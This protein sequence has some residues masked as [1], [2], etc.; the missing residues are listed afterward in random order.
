MTILMIDDEPA[1]PRLF[2]QRYRRERLAGLVEFHFAESGE[3]A[4]RWLDQN[5]APDMIFTDVSMPGMSGLDL[6][7]AIRAKGFDRPVYVVTAYESVDIAEDARKRGASGVLA[8]P[9][10]FEHLNRLFKSSSS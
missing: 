4:L 9:L 8:K 10:S 5:P 3:A 7:A 1:V 2:E 6:V